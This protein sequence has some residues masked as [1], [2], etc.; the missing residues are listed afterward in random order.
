MTAVSPGQAFWKWLCL[1][2]RDLAITL[3]N[4]EPSMSLPENNEHAGI[5]SSTSVQ[6]VFIPE[7]SLAESLQ[8]K[9]PD[10]MLK[11]K[12]RLWLI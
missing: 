8:V 2:H 7:V 1:R 10:S 11:P 4:L 5:L 3:S 6:E 12:D 9:Y